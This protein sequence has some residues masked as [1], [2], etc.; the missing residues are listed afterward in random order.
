M[1]KEEK[2]ILFEM[3][4]YDYLVSKL[5][6]L[7]TAYII[8]LMLLSLGANFE[9]KG[10]LSFRTGVI[11]VIC[12]TIVFFTYVFDSFKHR[13]FLFYPNKIVFNRSKYIKL[14]IKIIEIEEGYKILPHNVNSNTK[15][16]LFRWNTPRKILFLLCSPLLIP[17]MLTYSI[18]F[19]ISNFMIYR[20]F[21]LKRYRLLLIGKTE[22]DY[23]VFNYTGDNQLEIEQYFE[24]RLG[25]DVKRMETTKWF[26]IPEY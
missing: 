14:E 15:K 13:S 11:L 18:S 22:K 25:V 5:A 23:I 3:K 2:E 16:N 26:F 10:F 19:Y 20:S 8:L 4:D 12:G 21:L 7:V 24:E 9:D 17:F 1:N 6:D